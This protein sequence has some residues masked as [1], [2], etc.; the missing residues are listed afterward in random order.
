MENNVGKSCGSLWTND[1]KCKNI[2]RVVQKFL[3]LN[4]ICLFYGCF[5]SDPIWT[6][7][8]F[9]VSICE[10][11][12][13]LWRISWLKLGV[14]KSHKGNFIFLFTGLLK[15]RKGKKEKKR[16]SWWCRSRESSSSFALGYPW[17]STLITV[18]MIIHSPTW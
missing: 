10:H 7:T 11:G 13:S 9:S 18:I 6:F 8:F 1:V 4:F 14:G 5:I 12:N 3:L 17:M 15:K 16:P 2:E